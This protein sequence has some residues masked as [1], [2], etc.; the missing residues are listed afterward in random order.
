MSAT[1]GSC[2]PLLQ[3]PDRLAIV[4]LQ[5]RQGLALLEVAGAR[6]CGCGPFTR[7]GTRLACFATQAQRASNQVCICLGGIVKFTVDQFNEVPLAGARGECLGCRPGPGIVYAGVSIVKVVC[8][9]ALD[10]SAAKQ[11]ASRAFQVATMLAGLAHEP[12]SMQT[13]E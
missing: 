12:Y 1:A 9:C 13:L 8:G 7:H 3:V 2:R 4:G 10:R 6:Y 11:T 5:V